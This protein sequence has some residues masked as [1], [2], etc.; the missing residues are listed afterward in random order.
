M[1]EV[2]VDIFNDDAF[3]TIELTAAINA[4]DHIPGRAGEVAF[5]GVGEGVATLAVAIE[6][7]DEA[8]ALIQ[9]SARGAPADQVAGDKAVLKS[10]DI[11]QIKLEATIPIGAVQSVRQFGSTSAVVGPQSVINQRFAKMAG[12]HD[13]TLEYHRLGAL[14]GAILDADGT[15]LI[16]LFTLFGVA[17][18]SAVDFSD[19]FSDVETEGAPGVRSKCHDIARAMKRNLKG[20]WPNG[21]NIWAFCGDDFFDALTESARVLKAYDGYEAAERRLGESYAHGV[22]YHGGIY[23][24]N[25]RGTDDNSTVAITAKDARLFPVGIPGLYAEYYAP[26][27]FLETAN[28]IGLPRYAKI[29]PDGRFNRAVYL[30]TQQN[31][32]PLCLRPKVLMRAYIS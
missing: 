6:Q 5:A 9:T 12:R 14:E 10:V 2:M 32:L 20:M 28:T 23:W 3:S 13:L 25:Y 27:D 18:E 17:Q 8:L 1:P 11:P 19:V 30:H 16:N 22:F 21:A 7:K 15:T 4:V 31:P 24:E 26:A 29:A